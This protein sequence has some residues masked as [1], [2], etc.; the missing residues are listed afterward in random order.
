M[1]NTSVSI[2]I[3][4]IPRATRQQ[5]KNKKPFWIVAQG[6]AMAGGQKKKKVRIEQHKWGFYQS[7]Q[8]EIADQALCDYQCDLRGKQQVG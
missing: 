5:V 8:L 3:Q 4:L 7:S 1:N 6:K 2:P